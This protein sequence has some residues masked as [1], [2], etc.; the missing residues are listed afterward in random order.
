L[1]P[2]VIEYRV[3]EDEQTAQYRRHAG[4]RNRVRAA[5]AAVGS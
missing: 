3:V 5:G 2:A 1:A 4:Q